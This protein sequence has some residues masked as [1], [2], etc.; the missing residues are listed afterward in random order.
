MGKHNSSLTR[1]K[2]LFDHINSDIEE[3]NCFL[4]LFNTNHR[5]EPNTLVEILYENGVGGKEKDLAPSKSLLIWMLE[6]LEE[7]NKNVVNFGAKDKDSKTYKKR[8]LLFSGDTNTF[9]EAKKLI[10]EKSERLKNAWYIFEG[11]THP[12]IYIETNDSIFIGEAK[13]TEKDITTNTTWLKQRD[14]LIRH[15]DSLLDLDQSKNIYSFYILENLNGCYEK[16]MKSYLDRDYFKN[17]L[18]HRGDTEID[19]AFNSFIG[20]A[21]WKDIADRFNI[22]FPDLIEENSK[23]L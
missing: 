1:V 19:R 5:I 12:D 9:E 20:Y 17:N 2:P 23:N 11:F 15:I 10:Q 18:K 16:S 13:R 6:N 14:Q 22:S 4:G 21:F 8:E 7:L 3:L